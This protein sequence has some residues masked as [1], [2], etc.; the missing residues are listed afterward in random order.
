M[1]IHPPKSKFSSA[2]EKSKFNVTWYINLLLVP[3]FF[4]L[5]CVHLIF[6]DPNVATSSTGLLM[7]I[8]AL[9]IQY[10]T[11]DYKHIVIASVIIG[12]ILTQLSIYV[13][14]DSQLISDLMWIMLISFYSYYLIGS[15]WG[16]LIMVLNITGLLISLGVYG[17]Y[18]AGRIVDNSISLKTGINVG[19]VTIVIAYIIHKIIRS[20]E[21]A[22]QE[23]Q[24]ANTLLSAQNEEKTVLL[25]EVH[26]R[27]KNNLQLIS[28]LLRLQSQGISDKESELQFNK[29]V[30][31]IRSIA[32][33]HEK[34]YQQNE[35]S[36]IDLQEY[37]NTL[38]NDILDSQTS[39]KNIHTEIKSEHDRIDVKNM[40]PLALLFNELVTNSIKHA[41][42]DLNEGK[43]ELSVGKMGEDVLISYSDNG[44]WVEPCNQISFGTELIETL[45]LQL[46]GDLHRCTENGT[47]Y[48]I[49][50]NLI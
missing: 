14:S 5:A 17:D 15:K 27:V 8:T 36:K 24:K 1:T 20:S 44:N 12:S 28:S 45:C 38:I 25:K 43:I 23:L 35:L 16:A 2:L 31:R 26:H 34:M 10:K 22:N 29:A 41:F 9:I 30:N 48:E 11:K 3:L 42:K 6:N 49:K 37:L 50:C 19:I 33:I 46:N 4:F 21:I 32:L 13:I 7:S 40:V 47:K 39:G 18:N